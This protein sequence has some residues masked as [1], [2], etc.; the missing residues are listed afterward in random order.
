ML[1]PAYDERVGGSNPPGHLIS[2]LKQ[3]MQ[4]NYEVSSL[5]LFSELKMSDFIYFGTRNVIRAI[6]TFYKVSKKLNIN[7]EGQFPEEPSLL[8][9]NHCYKFKFWWFGWHEKLA[10]HAILGVIPTKR[11]IHFAVQGKQYMHP[12]TRFFLERLETFSANHLRKGVRYAR[13]GETVAIFP[14]GE[15]HKMYENKYY[16]GAS[17]IAKK[18]NV[19]IT[20]LKIR[21][22]GR[23]I[24]IKIPPKIKTSGKT[25]EQITQ[26]IGEIYSE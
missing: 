24:T 6:Y 17:F 8:T 12:L 13:K 21:R 2:F 10:D 9:I 16:D 5:R 1:S 11:K 3:H 15:A 23:D 18:G 25:L 26:E 7:I 19:D 14:Q 22:E 4:G 20:P